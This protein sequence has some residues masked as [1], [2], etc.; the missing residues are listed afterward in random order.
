MKKTIL[1]TGL[2]VMTGVYGNQAFAACRP[3]AG[4]TSKDISMAVGRVV[5]RP[6]DAIGTILAK[7]TFPINPVGSTIACDAYGGTIRADLTQGYPLSTLG[8]NIYDTNIPGIG[9]RLYR[10]AQDNTNFSGYYPYSKQ[11]AGN[12][13]YTLSNGFFVVEIIKTANN[14][15]SG[16]LVP[17]L[18]SSYYSADAPT[19]PILT[20][21]VYGNAI[22][23]ASASC[24]V[25]G[26][27]NKV[28]TLSPVAKSGFTGIGSTQ[29]E[30]AFNINILC[31]GGTNTTSAI[32]S[33]AISVS[34]DYQPFGGTTNVID[35][36]ASATQLAAGVGT[37]LLTDMNGNL[38]HVISQGEKLPLGLVV[39]GQLVNYSIPMKARYYQAA[40]T[41]TAGAV[42]GMATLTI[43]YE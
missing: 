4:F 5:V 25:T 38:N 22:T 23:I 18:Y 39:S 21:T 29:G 10:E 13:N 8:Q 36:S 20:S 28:V 30:Q 1:M 24:Q 14:T 26:D 11:L 40:N 33:N 19:Q 43:I 41:V 42:R 37:Q 7:A 9:I 15:G 27:I 35:N 34:F 3:T 2:F 16:A 17:G 12:T 31:N 6:S 32:E